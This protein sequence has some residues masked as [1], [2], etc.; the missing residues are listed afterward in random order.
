M[1]STVVPEQAGVIKASIKG[2]Q[3]VAS[4]SYHGLM[5][6]HDARSIQNEI[7][8]LL[9]RVGEWDRRVCVRANRASRRRAIALFF[10]F[11][12]RLGN[13]IFWYALML[14]LLVAYRTEAA[15]AVMHMVATGLCCT[16]LYKW[17][18]GK[19]LRVRPYEVDAAIVCSAPPLDKFS[20]PSG[21]TLHAVAFSM[22]AMTYYPALAWLVVPFS[23]LVALSRVVLG[24]HYPSDV[25]AGASIGAAVACTALYIV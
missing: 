25:L 18:K 3:S 5:I 20:F 7:G 24:L 17:L 13:G 23:I 15:P 11:V 8:F 21:H 12:S 19:T 6:I 16:A 14:A 9:G 2:N 4:D 22:V 10:A 1:G